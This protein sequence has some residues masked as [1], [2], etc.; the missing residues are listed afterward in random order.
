MKAKN[1]TAVAAKRKELGDSF[2][3]NGHPKG[4][5]G[6]SPYN[7]GKTYEELYG[8]EEATRKKE[9]SRDL[10]K[11]HIVGKP[12]SEET[13]KF[14][15]DLTTKRHAEGWD[16]KAGRC[17]KYHYSSPIAGNM[18]LDGTWELEVAMYL[19][20]KKYTWYRNTKQ[21]PYVNLNGKKS[22][23]T[24]DFYVADFNAYLEIKGYETELDRCKWSQFQHNLIV[25]KK[26]ELVEHG[27]LQKKESII[28]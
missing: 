14:L 16:N 10:A 4:M 2:W 12:H 11:K 23:Y 7:K 18:T 20:S 15:S 22:T 6:K 28:L 9:I 19:D 26:K 27:L 1:G 13:K 17:K 24:P 8:V 21:F 3:K 5:S 25:W